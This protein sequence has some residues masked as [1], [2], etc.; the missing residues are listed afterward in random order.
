MSDLKRLRSAGRRHGSAFVRA[1]HAIARDRGDQCEC[2]RR[3]VGRRHRTGRRERVTNACAREGS[4]IIRPIIASGA[5]SAPTPRVL[6][7]LLSQVHSAGL[8][9]RQPAADLRARGTHAVARPSGFA[10]RARKCCR[11]RRRDARSCRPFE[12]STTLERIARQH[13]ILED[14][15]LLDDY[16]PR[17]P[18]LPPDRCE[19]LAA[20]P[21]EARAGGVALNDVIE[22]ESRL[23]QRLRA[24]R[25]ARQ[26]SQTRSRTATAGSS[27]ARAR[28]SPRP[29]S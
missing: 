27:T 10:G 11:R 2:R 12:Q 20:L 8:S 29:T 15:A 9:A 25:P 21:L 4:V 23:Y 17:A 18:G 16:L 3:A 14:N 13:L 22:R 1:D 26:P 5:I 28:C 24:P 7:A 19:Q 6:P